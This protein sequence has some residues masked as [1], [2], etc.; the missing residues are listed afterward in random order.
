MK[1]IV[2]AKFTEGQHIETFLQIVGQAVA[3]WQTVKP[4]L[5]VANANGVKVIT[6]ESIGEIVNGLTDPIQAA[7]I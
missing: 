2:E 5:I 3:D 4:C 7:L 6:G 1:K